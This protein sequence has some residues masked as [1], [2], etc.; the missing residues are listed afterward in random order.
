MES[1]NGYDILL[2]ILPTTNEWSY[3]Y[4]TYSK[5]SMTSMYCDGTDNYI[6]INL[7]SGT[8]FLLNPSG[9]YTLELG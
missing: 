8:D 6:K 1:H 7:D 2:K 3:N 5:F 9:D 4:R